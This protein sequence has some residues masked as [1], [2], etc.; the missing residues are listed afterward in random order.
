[1][2]EVEC[3]HRAGPSTMA[4]GGRVP[5]IALPSATAFGAAPQHGQVRAVARRGR[6]VAQARHRWRGL[7]LLPAA[8]EAGAPMLL[9]LLNQDA[10]AMLLVGCAERRGAGR[11][12]IFRCGAAVRGA[13]GARGR[14]GI[15]NVATSAVHDAHRIGRRRPEAARFQSL[16]LLVHGDLQVLHPSAQTPDLVG[17]HCVVAHVLGPIAPIL[18]L[19]T[20]MTILGRR[21]LRLSRRSRGLA[22]LLDLRPLGL[23]DLSE[24]FDLLLA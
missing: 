16:G 23:A 22:K 20:S 24:L 5:Q 19:F 21:D 10:V 9:M 11:C 7:C 6:A 12:R 17:Q 8:R 2:A 14:R 15:R 3:R 4:L 1:M 18:F 13:G